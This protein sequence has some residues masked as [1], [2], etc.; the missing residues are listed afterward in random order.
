MYLAEATLVELQ[1]LLPFGLAAS[2]SVI[3]CSRSLKCVFAGRVHQSRQ[4]VWVE[5]HLVLVP[6]LCVLMT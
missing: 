3:T 1:C 6:N 4:Q 2:N 5:S